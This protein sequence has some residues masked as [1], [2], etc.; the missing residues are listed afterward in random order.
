MLSI[1]FNA[2]DKPAYIIIPATTHRI[3]SG[4]II[5]IKPTKNAII[6]EVANTFKKLMMSK[7][8]LIC[9]KAKIIRHKDI[10]VSIIRLEI[11]PP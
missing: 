1:V 9:F 10:I 3:K 8:N 2:N 5:L 11:A 7:D 4:N 6:A